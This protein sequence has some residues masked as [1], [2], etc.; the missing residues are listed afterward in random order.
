MRSWKVSCQIQV[1]TSAQF[2]RVHVSVSF[3]NTLQHPELCLFSFQSNDLQG[4]VNVGGL[5]M[6]LES[7]PCLVNVKVSVGSTK[8]AVTIVA[9]ICSCY[10]QTRQIILHS[11]LQ[12]S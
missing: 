2:L 7:K 3:F 6:G 11:A 1:E 12:F 9:S 8:F 4:N 5:D 10:P